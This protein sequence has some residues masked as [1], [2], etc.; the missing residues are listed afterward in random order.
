M[1]RGEMSSGPVSWWHQQGCMV[2]EMHHEPANALGGPLVEG[3]IAALDAADALSEPEILIFKSGLERIFAAGADIKQMA[4]TDAKGF[5]AYCSGVREVMDRIDVPQRISIAA[6]DGMALGGGTE[7]AIASTLRVASRAAS[8]GLPEVKLGLIPGAGGTQRLPELVGKGRALDL[9][10]SARTIDAEEAK[11][12]GLIDRLVDGS[13]LDGALA[14]AGQLSAMSRPALEQVV[15]AVDAA[16]S[17]GGQAGFEAEAEG[18][19]QLFLDGDARQR[20][21]D[22]VAARSARAAR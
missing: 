22:F 6:I 2:I 12:I 13:A 20:L 18:I 3:L 11:A 9:M 15:A 7:L 1:V 8:F 19:H 14:L 10:L 4:A 5:A 17:P 16:Y 21:Q